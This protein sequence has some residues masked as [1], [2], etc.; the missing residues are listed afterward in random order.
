[1]EFDLAVRPL[2]NEVE[3]TDQTDH[4]AAAPMGV[5]ITF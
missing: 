5:V 2:H 4:A 1:M 3:E